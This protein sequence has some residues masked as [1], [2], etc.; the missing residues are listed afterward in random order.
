MRSG[1]VPNPADGK[2]GKQRS[3]HN[4]YFTL[5]VVFTMVSNHYAFTYS[6]S[7]NWAILMLIAGAGLAIR[8]FFVRRHK[9][10]LAWHYLALAAVMLGTVG[11]W[12]TPRL[13]P[14]PPVNGPV[15]LEDVRTIVGQR[16][17]T[18]HSPAPTFAGIAQPP[19]GVLL[20]T[21]DGLK[22]HAERIYQQVVV[23]R[24]MPLGN[25]TG[26]TDYERAVI[27]TWVKSQK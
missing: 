27:A 26:M 4:N 23:S 14:L 16:C 7:Y 10:V 24:I 3:V 15:T 1:G 20:T 25:A 5:P 22:Q 6:H 11:W 2:R 13:A 17:V 12:T 19:A 18:C 21:T 8:H 9:G